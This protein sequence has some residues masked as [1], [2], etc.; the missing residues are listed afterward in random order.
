[1]VLAS[2]KNNWHDAMT[3]DTNEVIFNPNLNAT[4]VKVRSLYLLS[5]ASKHDK[6][7][8]FDILGAFMKI[9]NDK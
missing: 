6:M 1:M 9:H 5:N 2:V 7:E 4:S 3:Y 8:H